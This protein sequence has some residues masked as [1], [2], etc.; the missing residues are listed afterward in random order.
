[1]P[2]PGKGTISGK[3]SPGRPLSFMSQTETDGAVSVLNLTR[4]LEIMVT[5]I[6]D[7]VDELAHIDPSRVL[8]CI[9]STR[10]A[11]IHGT[12]AKIHPLRFRGG[13]SSIQIRRGGKLR[14]LTMPQVTRKGLDML[15]VIYFLAPRFFN[16]PQREK[17]ITI[18]HELYHISPDF[19]GDIRRFPGRNYAHG[20]SRKRYN[21][22]MAG[23]VDGYLRIRDAAL[24]D[25]LDLDMT[26]LRQH[27]RTIVGRRFT[28][29][30]IQIRE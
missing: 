25:F 29:P 9:A 8:I 5:D 6:V 15:Y 3:P 22:A 4:E 20:S 14:T 30:R 27:Y 16:L 13:E 10:G 18:F 19:D 17:L 2:Q 1:M 21:T 7:R 26:G 12:F 28:T 11:G 24:P 23:L